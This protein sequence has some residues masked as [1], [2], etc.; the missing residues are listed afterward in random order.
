MKQENGAQVAVQTIY[1]EL[2]RARTLVKKHAK[3]DGDDETDDFDDEWTIIEDEEEVEFG[4][5]AMLN[6]AAAGMTNPSLD[7]SGAGTLALGSMVL[8]GASAKRNSTPGL[9]GRP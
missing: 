5:Q 9:Q 1:R 6:E 4:N 3:K 2:E 7:R 8:K